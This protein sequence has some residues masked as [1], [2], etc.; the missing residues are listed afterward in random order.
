MLHLSQLSTLTPKQLH[1]FPFLSQQIARLGRFD[2]ML[3]LERWKIGKSKSLDF[4]TLS[5]V[6][7]VIQLEHTYQR[8]VI[9][10]KGAIMKATE[11]IF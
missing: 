5:S 4:T 2:G 11:N 10:V 7:F 8:K 1:E 3:F 9:S 6:A